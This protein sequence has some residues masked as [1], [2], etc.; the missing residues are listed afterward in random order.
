[1]TTMGSAANHASSSRLRPVGVD[2]ALHEF[3][4]VIELVLRK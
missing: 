3:D 4:Q 2:N 1:M